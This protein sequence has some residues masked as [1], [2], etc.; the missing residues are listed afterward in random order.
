MPP[1]SQRRTP[2]MELLARLGAPD[3]HPGG[4]PASR[5][6]VSLVRR[7]VP[8]GARI[9]EV[10]AGAGKTAARLA[11]LG[12]RV[13]AVERDPA[14]FRVLRRRAGRHPKFAFVRADAVRLPFP[15]ASFDAVVAE[16]VL[17]FLS[18]KALRELRRVLR[19]GGTLFALELASR[20]PFPRALRREWR[21]FYGVSGVPTLGAWRRRLL[22]AG[23]SPSFVAVPLERLLGLRQPP[24]PPPRSLREAHLFSEHNRLFLP[25]LSDLYLLRIVATAK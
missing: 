19:P 13:F 22:R 23:F 4:A 2:Y 24:P 1:D 16:S 18:P 3:A 9:L 5:A 7:F 12:Y 25:H 21:A 8:L 15:D 10:G 20:T 6:F 14:Y 17:L 11:R